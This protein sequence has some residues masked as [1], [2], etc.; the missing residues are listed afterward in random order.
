MLRPEID[1]EA[2]VFGDRLDAHA[3]TARVANGEWRIGLRFIGPRPAPAA[4]GSM[5]AAFCLR[6]DIAP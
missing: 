5:L 4:T 3:G 2:P 6:F 1:A